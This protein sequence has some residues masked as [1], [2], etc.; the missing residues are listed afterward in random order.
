M[1]IRTEH[2]IDCDIC[3][4]NCDWSS[5]RTKKGSESAFLQNGWTKKKGKHICK[6]CVEDE[7]SEGDSK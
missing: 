2:R 1:V 7:I 4:E 6:E 3:N 5:E